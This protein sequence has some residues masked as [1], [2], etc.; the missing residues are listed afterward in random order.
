MSEVIVVTGAPA[1]L[2]RAIADRFARDAGVIGLIARGR[3]RLESARA[4]LEALS[5]AVTLG[6]ALGTVRGRER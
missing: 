6:A 3:S 1:G 5:G 2:R 4:S